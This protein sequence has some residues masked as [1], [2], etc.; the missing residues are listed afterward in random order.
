MPASSYAESR[1]RLRWRVALLLVALVGVLMISLG[2]LNTYLGLAEAARLAWLVFI[3]NA[4][5]LLALL[6]LPQRLGTDLF[7][8][9][10]IALL[11]FAVGFGAWYDRPLYYWG[12]LFPPMIVFL[13]PAWWALGAMLLFGAFAAVVASTQVP[14]IDV[15]RIVS[16]YGLLVCFV[17]TYAL[18]EERASRML[19]EQS[20]RDVLTGCLNRRSFNEALA[21]VGVPPESA[22]ALG[23]L[24]IDIDHFKCINDGRPPCIA[25]A[26]RSSRSW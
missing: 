24:A 26:A 7:F 13:L 22:F 23:V 11:V 15:A 9:I 16:V 19:R 10:G 25:M 3:I 18:L 1:E 20:D 6:L 4:I 14:L 12:Y 2:L 17:T 5:S 21:R 8:A